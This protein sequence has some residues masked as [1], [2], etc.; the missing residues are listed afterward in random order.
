MELELQGLIWYPKSMQSN[1]FTIEFNSH[2]IVGDII[3]AQSHPDVL[4]L[5][6]AG[7]ANIGRYSKLRELLSKQDFSSCGF[8]YIGHGKTGG[9]LEGS[10]LRERTETT[11]EVIKQVGFIPQTIIGSSMGAYTAI[12]L[13]EN[14]EVKNLILF[15]PAIYSDESY[16]IPFGTDFKNAISKPNAWM[17]SRVWGL[18][19]SFRGKLLIVTAAKDK[20]VLP[21]IVD[22]LFDSAS[23]STA[24]ELYTVDGASHSFT[25][26]L[27]ENDKQLL[28]LVNK[29]VNFLK[30]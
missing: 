18:L 26:F 19:E 21:E 27:N 29:I 23:S 4:V 12:R 16:T 6:G 13:L 22:K 24:S 1:N 14:F 25:R 2:K 28:G 8:D 20:V 9:F 3:P 15:V 5:H 10:S 30:G 17:N 7:S 11:L